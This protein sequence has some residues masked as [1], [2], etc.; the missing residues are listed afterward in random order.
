MDLSTAAIKPGLKVG[1][2]PV[3]FPI[4]ETGWFGAFLAA[5]FRR[6]GV[7]RGLLRPARLGLGFGS[8]AGLANTGS[9][10]FGG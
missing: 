3:V 1:N 5:K 2:D 10:F 4:A 7:L 9:D 8:F 6:D